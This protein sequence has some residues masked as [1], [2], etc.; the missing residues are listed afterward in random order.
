MFKNL[1]IKNNNLFLKI[2][3]VM[4]NVVLKIL[5]ILLFL[6]LILNEPVNKKLCLFSY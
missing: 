1:K 5:N 6:F 2:A 4:R 3:D